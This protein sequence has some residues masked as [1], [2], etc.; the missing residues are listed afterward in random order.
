M[1]DPFVPIA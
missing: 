1:E